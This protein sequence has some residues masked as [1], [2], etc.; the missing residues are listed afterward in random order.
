MNKRQTKKVLRKFI[1]KRLELPISLF[2]KNLFFKN[3]K[4][5]ESTNCE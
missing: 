1:K 2:E 3:L 5:K 4:S